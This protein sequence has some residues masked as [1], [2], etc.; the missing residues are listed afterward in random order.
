MMSPCIFSVLTD[1][2]FA[3][4]KGAKKRAYG[5]GKREAKVEGCNERIT[6]KRRKEEEGKC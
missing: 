3:R 2:L 4:T 5:K 6:M 1:D